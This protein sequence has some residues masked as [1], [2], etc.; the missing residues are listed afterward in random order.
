MNSTSTASESM[1]AVEGASAVLVGTGIVTL[2]L[3]PLA[4]PILLV[5]LVFTAPLLL[6]LVP[7]ALVG[8]IIASLG[9]AARATVR[10]RKRVQSPARTRDD[11]RR[12]TAR[13]AT[14]SPRTR[15]RSGC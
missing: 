15:A 2:A 8:A 10:W 12:P 5:T 7:V 1:G 3:F 14:P 13:L 11:A 4:I 6:V 9:L